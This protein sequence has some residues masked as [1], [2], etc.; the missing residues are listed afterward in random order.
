MPIFQVIVLAVVQGLTEFLPISS[1]AHLYLTSWLLGWQVEGLDF[2]I[3]LHIGT[4]LAVI[5]YFFKDWVQIIG[6]GL[7][8]NVGT[9]EELRHNRGMLWL[10][11]IATVPVGIAGLVFGKQAE[12]AWRNPYVIAA[13]MIAVGVL[14]WLAENAARLQRDLAS[15][16]APD[17]VT[18]GLFQALAVVPGTSRSGV[19]ISAGLFRNLNREAAARFSFLA[20]TPAIAAAAGKAIWDMKKHGGGLHGLV[21][22]SFLVGVAVSAIVGCA[23]IAWFL[24]YLRRSGLRPFVY[25]RIVFGV[26]VLVLAFLRGPA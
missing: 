10:L 19:T 22:P 12:G 14:M 16:N 21:E 7:G 1:T 20:S 24:Q 26:I 11:A 13:M 25:Y 17:A 3:A 23:V 9:D 18:I 5:L 4:L 15:V 2:D 6:Q 8:M